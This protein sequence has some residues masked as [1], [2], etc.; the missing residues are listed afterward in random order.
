[1]VS[2]QCLQEIANTIE[3]FDREAF[4]QHECNYHPEIKK[5]ACESFYELRNDIEKRENA[6]LKA[7]SSEKIKKV[8]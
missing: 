6:L 3:T 7:C 8:V 2:E 4:A 5:E 1:M